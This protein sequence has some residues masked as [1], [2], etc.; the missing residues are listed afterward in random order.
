MKRRRAIFS[1]VIKKDKM[2]TSGAGYQFDA[3]LRDLE[4]LRNGNGVALVQYDAINQ[5]RDEVATAAKEAVGEYVGRILEID[6]PSTGREW[7]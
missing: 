2:M 5:D 6:E 3:V 4:Y 1:A 7:G